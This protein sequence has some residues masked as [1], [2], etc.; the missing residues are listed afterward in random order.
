MAGIIVGAA[1]TVA[2]EAQQQRIDVYDKYSR[3]QAYAVVNERQGRIDFYDTY[4]RRTGYATFEPRRP[5]S[6]PPSTGPAAP[7]VQ[8]RR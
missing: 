7:R 5:S 4:S 2:V 1:A 3:R 6:R 8:P